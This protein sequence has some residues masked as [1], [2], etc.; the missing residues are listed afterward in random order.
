MKLSPIRL[1]VNLLVSLALV[2]PFGISG[3]AA[4]TSA[5]GAAV[6]LL[7]IF[8]MNRVAGIRLRAGR[9]VAFPFLALLMAVLSVPAAGH[10]PSGIVDA[11]LFLAYGL[12][13]Y[14][15]LDLGHY[16]VRLFRGGAVLPQ[17][18]GESR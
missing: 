4:G 1:L 15:Y 8:A 3:I 12:F 2:S 11:I 10:L 7:W 9:I 17:R 5:T 14:R 6:F 16:L 13:G 18:G